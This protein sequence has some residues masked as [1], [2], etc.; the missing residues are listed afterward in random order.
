MRHVTGAGV[1]RRRG[2]FRGGWLC[3]EALLRTVSEAEA[4]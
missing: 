2:D 1:R 3:V 4:F